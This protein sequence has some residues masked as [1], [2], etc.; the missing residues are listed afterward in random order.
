MKTCVPLFMPGESSWPFRW[1]CRLQRR[2]RTGGNFISLV[3]SW[4]V[5]KPG[6]TA[7]VEFT[8]VNIVKLNITDTPEAPDGDPTICNQSRM[9]AG[10]GPRKWWPVKPGRVRLLVGYDTRRK[11]LL[12]S[13]WGRTWRIPSI[14]RAYLQLRYIANHAN[15]YHTFDVP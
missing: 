8:A 6:G 14:W 9:T 12:P 4:K 10:D 7:S 1:I 3:M 2:W 11:D 15:A 13:I 5:D